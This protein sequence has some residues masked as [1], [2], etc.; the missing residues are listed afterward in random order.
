MR[1]LGIL[2]VMLLLM[3]TIVFAV[4]APKTVISESTTGITIKYPLIESYAQNT[5]MD[6]YFNLY[7][8]SNGI[9]FYNNTALSCL[10]HLY[11]KEGEHLI[12]YSLTNRNFDSTHPADIEIKVAGGNYS[13]KGEYQY[14]F[15]CNTSITGGYVANNFYITKGGLYPADDLLTTFIYILFII[16]SCGL[17]FTLLWNIAKIATMSITV[18]DIMFSWLFILLMLITIYLGENYLLRTFVE[19][20]GNLLFTISIFSN[21]LLPVIGLALTMLFN[22]FQQKRPPTVP[23]IW[24]EKR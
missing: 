13:T 16:S 15:Q 11:N 22:T 5:S 20:N 9:P 21:G 14:I 4:P 23:E 24:G 19:D 10:F 17:L 3:S 7:N 1:N 6:F 18:L 8:S 12:D 2:I